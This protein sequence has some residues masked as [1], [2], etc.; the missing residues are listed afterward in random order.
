MSLGGGLRTVQRGSGLLTLYQSGREG[1]V[2]SAS[3]GVHLGAFVSWL[4][5]RRMNLARRRMLETSCLTDLGQRC[6]GSVPL[7]GVAGGLCGNMMVAVIKASPRMAWISLAKPTIDDAMQGESTISL[8]GML[9]GPWPREA[10]R[11][12]L[13]VLAREVAA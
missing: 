7:P 11:E 4:M 5:R 1:S 6:L 12:C 2:E 3:G 10:K 9:P 8:V 13:M